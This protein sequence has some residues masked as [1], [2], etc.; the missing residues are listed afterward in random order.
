MP[1]H[2]SWPQ[3]PGCKAFVPMLHA[4]V[5]PETALLS[6]IIHVQEVIGLMLED[7]LLTAQTVRYKAVTGP[8]VCFNTCFKLS[9]Q[10]HLLSRFMACMTVYFQLYLGT[11]I[12]SD[13]SHYSHNNSASDRLHFLQFN[14]KLSKWS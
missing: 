6:H 2:A 11:K 10:K 9:R 4:T 13:L 12:I 3:W 14:T 8:P 7:A 1:H 5:K